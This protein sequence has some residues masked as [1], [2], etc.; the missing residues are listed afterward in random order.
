V[1]RTPEAVVDEIL[2]ILEAAEHRE[3]FGEPVSQLAHALQAAELARNAGSSNEV[4][5]A[6]LLHDLGHILDDPA[7]VRDG[8]VG[9]INHDAIAGRYLREH[10]FSETVAAL[11]EA[12]VDAKRYLTATNPAYLARLSPASTETLRLQG[13]PMDTE[14]ARRFAEHSLF[15]ERLQLRSWDEEAKYPERRSAPLSAY[16]EMLIAHLSR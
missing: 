3:Y 12:H 5:I 2:A 16:R 7:S 14:E 6:A 10:G 11:V 9:V 1:D 15:R 4:V 13:G 8:V